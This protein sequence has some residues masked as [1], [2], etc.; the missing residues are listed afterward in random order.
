MLN[1]RRA[2]FI[3]NMMRDSEQ[4]SENGD[5]PDEDFGARHPRARSR[6]TPG[7]GHH[8][9][10][11]SKSRSRTQ[12]P[13]PFVENIPGLYDP[14]GCA[15]IGHRGVAMNHASGPGIRENTLLSFTQAHK[16]GAEWCEFD[17]QVTSDGVPVVWHDDVVLVKRGDGPIDSFSVRE[18]EWADLKELSMAAK[19]T[20]ERLTGK[21]PMPRPRKKSAELEDDE[22]YD[23]LDDDEDDD[24]DDLD[25]VVFYRVFDHEHSID[26]ISKSL[27]WIMEDEDVIPTLSEVLANTPEELGFNIELKYDEHNSC[28]APRLVA[29]LRSILAACSEH[30]DRRIVFS[31]FDPDAATLMRALQG[32]YPVMILTDGEENH[33]D[34]RRRSV[35]A[36]MKV[37]LK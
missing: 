28:E 11:K 4:L 26:D 37:A 30:N 2:E 16:D 33:D 1:I 18:I 10:N 17:V 7:H 15:V 22:S 13:K 29:E 27:P 9:S 3:T 12:S 31:S 8:G 23:E 14:I 32:T 21:L 20:S 35:E 36:A 25:P 24:E 19:I 5:E 34:P 6:T